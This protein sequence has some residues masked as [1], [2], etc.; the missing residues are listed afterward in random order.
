MKLLLITSGGTICSS[1]GKQ[2][3]DLDT[4]K[5]YKILEYYQKAYP[6]CGITFD[7]LSPFTILSENLE[8]RHIFSLANVIREQSVKNYDGIILAHGTDSLQYTAS[9]LG[10][11]FS[12]SKIPI[13]LVSSNKVLEDDTA[14]GFANFCGAVAFIKAKPQGGVYV[15]YQNAGEQTVIHMG[16]RLLSYHVFTDALYSVNDKIA[17][18]IKQDVFERCSN[19]QYMPDEVETSELKLSGNIPHIFMTNAYVNMGQCFCSM[20]FHH[21]DYIMLVAYHS[22]TLPVEDKQFCAFCK[23]MQK[24]QVPIFVCGVHLKKEYRTSERFQELSLLPLPTAS[25][26]ALYSKLVL[27]AM[28]NRVEDMSANWGNDIID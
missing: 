14:N 20:D 28:N 5:Q 27:L 22:G 17:G 21:V 3:I 6:G 23:N 19:F 26:V 15:S 18:V 8:M 12:K 13:V 2:Y 25:P 7:T 16:T 10:Y 9:M 4:Q 1:A 24:R 11:L